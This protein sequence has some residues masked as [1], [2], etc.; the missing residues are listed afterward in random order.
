MLLEWANSQQIERYRNT[1]AKSGE[2]IHALWSDACWE[3]KSVLG[4]TGSE[5]L[6]ILSQS[7]LIKY[8]HAPFNHNHSRFDGI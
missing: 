6:T 5:R 1:Q 4:L 8:K 3:S 7:T 2:L